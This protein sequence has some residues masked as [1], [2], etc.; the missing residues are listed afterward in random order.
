MTTTEKC[1]QQPPGV[2]AESST[3]KPSS[4]SQYRT[5]PWLTTTAVCLDAGRIATLL[6]PAPRGHLADVRTG[7]RA[8]RVRHRQSTSVPPPFTQVVPDGR[9]EQQRDLPDTE[10]HENQQVQVPRPYR[11]YDDHPGQSLGRGRESLGRLA[12]VRVSRHVGLIGRSGIHG[13]LFLAGAWGGC[14]QA[15]AR[16][17]PDLQSDSRSGACDRAVGMA[18]T[19]AQHL[20]GL[21]AKSA[22][23]E[24]AAS[25]TDEMRAAVVAG[26]KTGP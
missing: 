1:A 7:R 3:P 12:L 24:A 14:T 11:T 10:C 23:V 18:R 4:S 6:I 5:V 22:R 9:A 19:F 21:E 15:T 26:L 25:G 13:A 2:S 17:L 8:P 20:S 16:L